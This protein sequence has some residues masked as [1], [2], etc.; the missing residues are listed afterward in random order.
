VFEGLF[1][2]VFFLLNMYVLYINIRI[3][4]LKIFFCVYFDF[5]QRNVLLCY[6]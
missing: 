1:K 5:S 2:L 4:L 3:H 6:Q